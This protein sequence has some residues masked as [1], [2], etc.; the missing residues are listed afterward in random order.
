MFLQDKVNEMLDVGPLW[1]VLRHNFGRNRLMIDIYAITRYQTVFF[2]QAASI[3][4]SRGLTK[5][6]LPSNPDS[7][8]IFCWKNHVQSWIILIRTT[9]TTNKCAGHIE[10]L[11]R[12]CWIIDCWFRPFI[13]RD[14][15]KHIVAGEERQI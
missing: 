4:I 13:I 9:K 12:T 10:N 14:L 15:F 8:C 5:R 2:G 3:K 1:H 6:I 7:L 11:K